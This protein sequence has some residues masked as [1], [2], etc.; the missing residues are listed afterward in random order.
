[1]KTALILFAAW[2]PI[3]LWVLLASFVIEQTETG[4]AV[5]LA[6]ILQRA[7]G[8]DVQS[9]SAWLLWWAILLSWL[10]LIRSNYV[11]QKAERA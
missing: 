10:A 6:D 4:D 2:T 11:R 7:T 1:M 9:Q 3:V 8:L 5:S